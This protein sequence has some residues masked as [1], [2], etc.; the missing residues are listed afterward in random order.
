[1]SWQQCIHHNEE[2][3]ENIYTTIFHKVSLN[4][5]FPLSIAIRNLEKQWNNFAVIFTCGKK[6]KEICHYLG[7]FIS[8]AR[9]Q[10]RLL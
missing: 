3:T 10:K 8:A 1:M 7:T 2:N 6:E 9:L 5:V 4:S